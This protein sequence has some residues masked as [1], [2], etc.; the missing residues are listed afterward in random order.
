MLSATIPNYL[1]FAKWVGRIKN[2]TIYIQN[3]LK[4]IVPLEHKIFLST[5]KNYLVRNQADNVIEENVHKSLRDLEEMNQGFEKNK[6]IKKNQVDKKDY[7]E[8]LNKRVK[9]F[10]KDIERKAKND[11]NKKANGYGNN[12]YNGPMVNN[13]NSLTYMK[14]EEIVNYLYKGNLTPVVIFVFSIKKIQEY[15]KAISCGE[16]KFVSKDESA[17]IIKFFDKCTKILKKEDREINQIQ[18]MRKMLPLGIGVHHAGLLP[19][20]KEIVEILYSK[21]LLKILFA[22]T[23]FSI[24]LNMPTRTVVFTEIMKFNEDNKE[25][26]SSVI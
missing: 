7:E 14:L 1:D 20:I 19:I 5:K 23:S 13:K 12:G 26:L 15:A 3:T 11:F 4:R 21:G 10:Y 25:I 16:Q 8:K 9:D 24:G 22:T 6:M 17:R 18:V 2:T